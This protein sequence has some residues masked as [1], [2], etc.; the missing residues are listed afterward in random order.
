[1]WHTKFQKKNPNPKNL[2][3]IQIQKNFKSWYVTYQLQKCPKVQYWILK[4][5]MNSNAKHD[6]V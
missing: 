6:H 5:G 4:N 1:M 3:K 2:K